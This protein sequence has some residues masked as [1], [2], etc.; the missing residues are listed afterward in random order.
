VDQLG[1]SLDIVI[2]QVRLFLNGAIKIVHTAPWPHHPNKNVFSD[3]Q[4]LW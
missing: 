2:N 1:L 4:I 3:C